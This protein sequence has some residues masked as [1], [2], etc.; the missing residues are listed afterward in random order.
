MFLY[1]KI[2][3]ITVEDAYKMK[4]SRKI[5]GDGVHSEDWLTVA[6]GWEGKGTTF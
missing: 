2:R 3:S 1:K 4:P 6:E 5:P